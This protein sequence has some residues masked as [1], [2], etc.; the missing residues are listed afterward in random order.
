MAC[1][2]IF[3]LKAFDP[4]FCEPYLSARY[5]KLYRIFRPSLIAHSAQQN[6]FP[7]LNIEDNIKKLSQLMQAKIN[8][9]FNCASVL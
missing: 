2:N 5:K 4:L 8:L 1:T 9:L 3:S 6:F 7:A